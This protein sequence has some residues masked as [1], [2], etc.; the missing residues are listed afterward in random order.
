MS[1]GAFTSGGDHHST[2]FANGMQEFNESN[3]KSKDT[4]PEHGWGERAMHGAGI[5]R[6]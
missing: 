2:F 5:P 6:T 1:A 3:Y 4:Q